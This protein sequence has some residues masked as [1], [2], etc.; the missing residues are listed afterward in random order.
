M[1]RPGRNAVNRLSSS[2]FAVASLLVEG[3]CYADIARQR[4]TS[5]RTVANQLSAAFRRLHVS[6]RSEMILRFFALDGVLSEAP[7]ARAG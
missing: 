6:G 5:T 2:E 3:H 4:S 1:P 7:P